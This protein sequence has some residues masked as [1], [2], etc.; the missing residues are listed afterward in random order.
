MGSSRTT[1]T[2]VIPGGV[3]SGV[4]AEADPIPATITTAAAVRARVCVRVIGILPAM[5]SDEQLAERPRGPVGLG[6]PGA[7]GDA[8]GLLDGESDARCRIPFGCQVKARLEPA[9]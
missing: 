7:I 4:A 5:R 1:S 9:A 6:P 8:H 2:S 3:V